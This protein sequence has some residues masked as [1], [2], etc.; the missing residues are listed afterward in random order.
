MNLLSKTKV[1]KLNPKEGYIASYIQ[2]PWNFRTDLIGRAVEIF[3]C[4]NG[5]YIKFEGEG[6]KLTNESTIE[7]RLQNIEAELSELK[8]KVNLC[9]TPGRIRTAVAGSKVLHD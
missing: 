1:K 9:N 5:F 7:T 3:Q 4:K 6:F 8:K 2:L